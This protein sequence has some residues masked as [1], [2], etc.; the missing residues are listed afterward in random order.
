[1][2]GFSFHEVISKV[3][4]P[5]VNVSPAVI[6]YLKEA[7]ELK[8]Y[9]P[10]QLIT[11]AGNI[12]RYFYIVVSGTQ[13]GYL[14]DRAGNKVVL[15]FSYPGNFTGVYDSFVTQKV[16]NYFVE[17]IGES[18]LLALNKA[19]F[20]GLFEKFPEMMRW[21]LAF[22]EMILSGR[23]QREVEML[24]LSA[25]ERFDHFMKRCPEELLQIPQKYLASYLNMKPETFSRMRAK[26][27]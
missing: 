17:S 22:I 4:E 19:G 5:F 7:T 3:F 2:E 14:I 12:E 25:S 13:A 9:S 11:E 15:A 6:D 27:N 1:M 21:R 18:Q 10:R 8:T 20:D 26:K 24:T 23:G 16:S